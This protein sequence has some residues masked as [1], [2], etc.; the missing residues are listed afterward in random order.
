MGSS[1]AKERAYAFHLDD[2]RRGWIYF[3]TV[4][5]FSGSFAEHGRD[6]RH[7]DPVFVGNF[8][9]IMKRIEQP[10]MWVHSREDYRQWLNDAGWMLVN[11]PIAN[12][13]MSGFL[14]SRVCVRSAIGVYWDV[15]IPRNRAASRRVPKDVRDHVLE[16]DGKRCIQCGETG[17]EKNPLTRDHV[18]PYSGGGETTAGNLV[19]LCRRCN[20]EYG[21]HSHPHLFVLAGLRH[22]WDPLLL[23]ARVARDPQAKTYAIMLSANMMVSRCRDGENHLMEIQSSC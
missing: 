17:T 5:L 16:R 11:A 22:D 23:S 15:A 8:E 20:Q 14:G 10:F 12:E 4:S 1:A 6:C 7:A 9:R 19:T 21:D 2:I 18:I 3:R 13:L